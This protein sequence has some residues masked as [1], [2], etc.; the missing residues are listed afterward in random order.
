MRNASEHIVFFSVARSYQ[1]FSDHEKM[2]KE[3]EIIHVILLIS[4]PDFT[5]SRFCFYFVGGYL[6]I[7]M[8]IEIKTYLKRILERKFRLYISQ[9]IE[10]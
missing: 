7:E 6:K 4:I 9:I 5:G 1:G 8:R 10:Y 2:R 3:R